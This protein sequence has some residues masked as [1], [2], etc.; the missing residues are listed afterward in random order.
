MA[1]ALLAGMLD[2]NEERPAVRTPGDAGHLALARPDQE[3]PDLAGL[4]IADQHLVVALSIEVP[5]AGVLAV[6][7]DP[8]HAVGVEGEAVGGVEHVV[9]VDV[10]RARPFVVVDQG[11]ARDHEQIPGE[12]AGEVIASIGPPPHDLPVD[13]L[14]A[15]IGSA[16][17]SGVAAGIGLHSAVLVVGEAAID[18]GPAGVGRHPFRPVHGGRADRGGGLPGVDAD[19]G[20]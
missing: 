8:E 3:P 6:G 16:D 11:I 9:L 14:R 2:A 5:A 12:S 18:L 4:G 15:R 20:P 7:L 17:G 10:V 19:L 1:V 13:V